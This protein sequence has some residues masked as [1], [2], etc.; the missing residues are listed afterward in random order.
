MGVTSVCVKMSTFRA[1][2]RL[3]AGLLKCGKNKVWL[4]PNEI[5]EI[6]QANSRQNVRKLIKDGL[7][8]KKPNRI[9]SRA[10]ARE[11]KEARRKGRHMGTGKR[12]GTANARTPVKSQWMRRM[13]VLRRMLRRYRESNKIER[14]LYH[15]LYLKCK[16]NVFKNKRVLMEHIH[17]KKADNTR[18]KMLEDQA[19]AR[20]IVAREARKRRQERLQAKK[21]ALLKE[22]IDS[23]DIGAEIAAQ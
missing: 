20:R 22:P 14:H 8:I 9:H 11:F 7:I 10:R 18:K 6:T 23:T 13:R 2:K 5:G 21:D 16:G 19:E 12:R 1:Q 3:A 4:D 15:E 17:K